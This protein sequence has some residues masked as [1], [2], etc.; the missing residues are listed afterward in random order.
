MTRLF[1]D[2]LFFSEQVRRYSAPGS[3]SYVHVLLHSTNG[4]EAPND[5]AVRCGEPFQLTD[6]MWICRLPTDLGEKVYEACESPGVPRQKVFRQYGQLY[7]VALFMGPPLA[8]QL[9]GWDAYGHITQFVGFSQLVHPTSLGFGNSIRFTFGPNGDFISAYPGPCR[10][11]TEHAFTIP[12][13]RNWICK[14]ECEQVKHLL[15]NTN[16]KELP[17]KAARAHWNVQHAAYQYFFEVKTLLIVTG[18]EALL[19]TRRQNSNGP[20]TGRQFKSRSV[21]LAELV[22]VPFTADDA[23]ELWDHRSD[24]SHGRDPWASRR[25]GREEL[26]QPPEL[27]KDNEPVRRYLRGEQLL[28][29]TVLKCL[30]DREFAAI[31][32][33]DDSVEDRFP[34]ADVTKKGTARTPD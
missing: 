32:A 8:G 13:H 21:R 2:D 15:A 33:S 11:M 6:R 4:H 12:P 31:F 24:V 16:P 10:G 27:T 28:R 5:N 23:N 19:H 30:T 1:G 3:N 29:T 18:L 22:G 17:D 34:I 9:T 7:T 25:N 14:Q 20:G 26:Q